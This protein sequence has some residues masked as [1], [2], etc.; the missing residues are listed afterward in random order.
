MLSKEYAA[1]RRKLIDQSRAI[2]FPEPGSPPSTLGM[3]SDEPVKPAAVEERPQFA[4]QALDGHTTSFSVVDQAGNAVV[5]TPTLGSGYGTGVVVGNTGMLFNNGIRIGSTSPYPDNVNYVR[6]GQIPI[7]NNSPIVVLK[8]GKLALTLGTPGGETIGQTQF[9]TL[10]NVLDFKMP[11]QEAIEAP[12]FALQANPNFYRA[13]SAVTVRIEGRFPEATLSALRAMGHTL[14]VVPGFGG[15]GN[16]QGILVN[17]KTGTMTA[18]ADP[19]LSG[20]AIGY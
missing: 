4:E 15:I 1:D 9:Q 11:I 16:M 20:Y 3:T 6:G 14:D 7:L 13:G 5:I 2:A 10:V 19:R 17:P 12:R 18:G 8:D